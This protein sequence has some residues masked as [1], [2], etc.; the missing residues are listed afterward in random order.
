MANAGPVEMN[1]S[2]FFITVSPTAWLNR[3]HTI[4]GEVTDAASQKVIDIAAAAQ[5]TPDHRPLNDV[6]IESV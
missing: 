3:K 5:Q 2:Q 4:F 1:G 6:A